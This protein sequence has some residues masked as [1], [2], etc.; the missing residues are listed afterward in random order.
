MSKLILMIRML[1]KLMEKLAQDAVLIMQGKNVAL[2]HVQNT[3][4]KT[5]P[6]KEVLLKMKG[7]FA[8]SAYIIGEKPQALQKR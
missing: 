1:F 5:V 4:M 3:S 8:L 6:K 7:S 2:R